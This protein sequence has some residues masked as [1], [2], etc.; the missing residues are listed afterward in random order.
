MFSSLFFLIIA[1]FHVYS[2]ILRKIRIP[3]GGVIVFTDRK[4]WFL[5]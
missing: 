5:Y 1:R 3:V 2:C 4:L